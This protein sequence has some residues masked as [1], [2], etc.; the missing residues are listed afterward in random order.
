MKIKMNMTSNFKVVPEGERELTITKAKCK[1]SGKPTRIDITF[2]DNEGGFVNSRY[3][4]DND[5]AMFAFA[6]LLEVALKFKD[7]DE[8]DTKEHTQQ[9]VGQKL[10]CEVVHTQGSQPNE[11]GE[12]PIF[13]NIKKTISLV[14]DN[15]SP[16]NAIS[17]QN[18]EDD[19]L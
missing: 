4:F 16:R 2:Q 6:K 8:F 15:D 13:A 11:N 9:L 17:N 18:D 10:I 5:N 1:P 19:D 3:A 7:G 14:A 12:L